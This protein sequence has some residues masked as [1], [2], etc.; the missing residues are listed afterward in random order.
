MDRQEAGGL[1]TRYLTEDLPGIGGWI[2]ERTEDF[3]VEEL[4]LYTPSGE[5][6]HTF[7]EI[8]K[9]GMSTFEAI[10]AIAKALGVPANRIGYAGLKDAQATTCQVLSVHGVPPNAITALDLPNVQVMW[11]ERH[12]NK[13]KI[14]HLHGNRFTVRIR[15]VEESAL[16]ACQSIL[17]VLVLRGV[18]NYYGP[19]RFGQRG[20]SA[21]LG[22]AVVQKD[23]KEFIQIFLGNPQPGEHKVVQHARARF[24]RGQWEEALNLFPGK[25]AEER[26]V[27]Q[28][29]LQTQ[30]DYPKAYAAVPKRLKTFLLSA[31]QSALFNRILD[32]R[33]NTLDRVY[34]GDLAVKHPGRSV[35][36]VE[37][38]AAEQPRADRFEISP[39]GPIFGFKMMQASGQQGEL[40]TATL[41]AEGLTLESFRI[42]QGIQAKGTRRALRFQVHDPELEYDEGAV[43]RFWL[44]RGCYATA[45]LAEIIKGPLMTE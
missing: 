18:P 2:K 35:F 13:L 23:A 43:L 5:G 45:L 7:F 21:R 27:L 36:R 32:A 10:R 14:G 12:R 3:G 26:R 25:M 33:L 39:T 34:D 1:R 41:E 44:P 9:T 4:P 11:A 29:M 22:R 38:G 15:G 8:R 24:E 30:G 42:G 6:E 16:P 28:V 31:Y 20:E 17:D 40:E 19:Q 37:D